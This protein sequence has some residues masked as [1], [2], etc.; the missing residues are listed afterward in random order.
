MAR[1]V[2]Y[3]EDNGIRRYLFSKSFLEEGELQGEFISRH[4]KNWGINYQGIGSYQDTVEVLLAH[5]Y[6]FV[7]CICKKDKKRVRFNCY[8]FF[9]GH[10]LF[11][12]EWFNHDGQRTGWEENTLID[13]CK[14]MK[15]N[16]ELY[17]AIVTPKLEEV[18]KVE[19]KKSRYS[20]FCK[21]CYVVL[22]SDNPGIAYRYLSTLVEEL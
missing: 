18:N 20:E 19:G 16:Y 13:S 3:F 1:F 5:S 7:R 22:V 9:K 2:E 21:T 12:F 15:R 14:I 4:L 11:E 17:D 8:L 10:L 6:S